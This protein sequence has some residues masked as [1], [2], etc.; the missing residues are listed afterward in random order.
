MWRKEGRMRNTCKIFSIGFILL[1]FLVN[2]PASAESQEAEKLKIGFSIDTLK[3]RWLRDRDE[4]VKRAEELG[5]EV[6]VRS[7]SGSDALQIAQARAMLVS[8][9]D[10]LVVVP[11][12]LKLAGRI[13]NV[14]HKEYNVK[15]IAYDRLIR[16]V[17]LDLYIGFDNE[18][19]GELQAEA[20]VARVPSGNYVI[21]G[22]AHTDNNA[23]LFHEG[24][25]NVLRPYIDR[26]EIKIIADQWAKDWLAP[27]AEKIM[28]LALD[29]SDNDVQA[30]LATNDVL[31]GGALK[32]LE[33]RGLAGKVVLSGQD[34]DL[35]AC[36]R[37]VAG[38]QAMT[39]YKPID[40]LAKRAAEVAVKMVRGQ[41]INHLINSTVNNGYKDVPAILLKPVAVDKKTLDRVI[42]KSGFHSRD[43][44]YAESS[45]E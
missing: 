41:K 11:H 5:V 18:R 44:V 43:E 26:G 3:E 24:Q 29:K 21:I 27:E 4:F 25:M 42:I 32:V 16:D 20:L 10:M 34:A 7:A 23:L 14:A 39:V 28:E 38:T 6:T 9:A 2:G 12:N 13:V 36:R 31:A 37:I 30:V 45:S 1:S 19:V 22:G 17:D 40:E 33:S 35:E 8:G 15:V